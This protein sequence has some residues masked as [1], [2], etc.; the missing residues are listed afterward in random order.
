[1]TQDKFKHTPGP[2]TLKH[3]GGSNFAVQR[4]E[5]RGVGLGRTNI[6]P[7][8]NK[9]TSA[10]DG[11]TICCSP[12]DALLISSAPE[13]LQELIEIAEYP[14]NDTIE[15]RRIARAAVIKATG[16]ST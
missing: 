15:M 8:F 10:I 4:F 14:E 3:V 6:A 2:W 9:D 5:I 1:M 13:L 16:E 12:Q 11:T 7:I